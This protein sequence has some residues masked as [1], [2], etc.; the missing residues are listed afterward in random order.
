MTIK[1][2]LS[3]KWLKA[4]VLGCL[5]ASSEIVLGSFLHNLRIPFT[6]NILTGIGIILLI[7]VAHIWKEKG[8]FWRSG[9]VC[10]LMKS[11]SPSA[12]IFGPMIA[13]LSEALLME[14]SVR[15]FRRN[16]FSFLLAGMLA[17]SWNLFHLLANYVIIYG[18]NIID[19][20]VNLTK[21]AQ[22]QLNIVND[23]YWLPVLLLFSLYMVLGLI[24]AIFGIYI[25][26]KSSKQ[27]LE[28]SSLTTAQVLEIKSKKDNFIFHFSIIWL[29]CNVIFLIAELS[30]MSFCDWEYWTISGVLILIIWSFRYKRSLRSLAKPKFWIFFVLLTMISAFVLFKLTNSDSGFIKGLL[31]GLEMNFRAAIT[32]VGFSAIGTELRNPRFRNI[33]VNSYIRQLPV[34]LEIAFD[35]LPLVIS[36]L[37]RLQDVFKRPIKIFHELVSQADFWLEKVEFK[38][39]SKDNVIILRGTEKTGKSTLLKNIVENLKQKNIKVGGFI[40][41]SVFENN[42]LIGYDLVDVRSNKKVVLSRTHGNKE[43]PNVGNYYFNKDC[44]EFGKQLVEIDNLKDVDIVVIDE[45]GPWEIKNQGWAKSLNQLVRSYKKPMIWVVRES[46]VNKV[47]ENWSL[48]NPLIADIKENNIDMICTNILSLLKK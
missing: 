47:I 16:I 14:F 5:W 42:I 9:L 35:T 40:A 38:I 1:K 39:N 37:P 23:N 48:K 26:R 28:T 11:L 15:I 44:I 45:V 20:Y 30:L 43:M 24:A 13:I 7:S 27:P 3:N 6:G 2:Q 10:A 33:F 25:G 21:F 19:L 17:M 34:A 36:N 4:S 31:I 18:A 22:K 29:L 46:I 32:I 8:L 41:P 12:V